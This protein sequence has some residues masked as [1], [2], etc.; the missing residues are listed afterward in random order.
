[1]AAF[2]YEYET[3]E[4]SR[5]QIPKVNIDRS[6]N[7]YSG[8]WKKVTNKPSKSKEKNLKRHQWTQK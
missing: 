1:M 3:V 7:S 5:K 2:S 6:E 4:I 8:D